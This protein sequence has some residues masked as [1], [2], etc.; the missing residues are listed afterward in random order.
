MLDNRW[1][2][3]RLL[4]RQLDLQGY[5][6]SHAQD[7]WAR[8]GNFVC[9]FVLRCS[10]RWMK[11]VHKSTWHYTI[12]FSGRCLEHEKVLIRPLL[13]E[14]KNTNI[15]GGWHLKF[16]FCFM[17]RRLEPLH[18][19]KL[20]FVHWKIMDIPTSLIRIISFFGGAFEFGGGSKFWCCVWT[21]AEPHC[22]GFCNFVQ[23]HT[24]L[25]CLSCFC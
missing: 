4:T 23:C 3:Y 9:H 25:N 11:N 14:S 17:E 6:S 2:Y 10:V 8:F 24:F 5:Q 22:V 18:F 20:S 15:A 16:K 21:N 1:W 19:E 13:R 12:L 7:C